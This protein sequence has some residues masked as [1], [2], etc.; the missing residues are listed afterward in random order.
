MSGA[1]KT[2]RQMTF[3]DLEDNTT[4]PESA[5]GTLL[6][7][8]PGGPPIDPS[9]PAVVRVNRTRRR[10]SKRATPTTA[11]CGPT[12]SA[13]SAS[14]ALSASLV[15]KLREQFGTG[16]SI[17]YTQTW[18]E[19]VTPLGRAYWAHTAQGRRTSDSDSTGWPTPKA[20]DSTSNRESVESRQ[21][22]NGALSADAANVSGWATPAATT[23]GGTPE[24]HIARKVR[25]NE[26]GAS[27]GLVVSNLDMQAACVTGW[28]TPTSRDHKD[29][30]CQDANVPVNGLLGR[31]AAKLVSPLPSGVTPTSSPVETGKVGAYRLNPAFSL[32]LMGF[33][34]SWMKCGKAAISASRSRARSPVAS[35]S[36]GAPV[37]PSASPPPPCSSARFSKPQR[38]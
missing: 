12:S 28:G 18:K 9:G 14:A 6:C 35:P 37:T 25:A 15:S 23:W 13:S 33:P 21:Q 4:S 30:A 32:W 3:A 24:Q 22:A 26:A 16:G 2:W 17:E 8:S 29:G 31:E 34:P 7:D 20:L 27:C 38:A 11:T 19:K 36:C 10:A 1:S 5:G